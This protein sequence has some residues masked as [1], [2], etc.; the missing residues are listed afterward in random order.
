MHF[1]FIFV[2]LFNCQ[3]K[4]KI[5]GSSNRSSSLSYKLLRHLLSQKVYNSARHSQFICTCTRYRNTL[6]TY[7]LSFSIS[8]SLWLCYVSVSYFATVETFTLR[9]RVKWEKSRLTHWHKPQVTKVY[10]LGSFFLFFCLIWSKWRLIKNQIIISNN[11][12]NSTPL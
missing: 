10:K 7:P 2:S 12:G 6:T 9:E 5:V 4:L 3:E 1:A 8:L 11:M